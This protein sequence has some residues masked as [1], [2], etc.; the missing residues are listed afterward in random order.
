MYTKSRH[1][2][3]YKSKSLFK[4]EYKTIESS[5]TTLFFSILTL[6]KISVLFND[7]LSP[8]K[9]LRHQNFIPSMLQQFSI[10]NNRIQRKNKWLQAL[11]V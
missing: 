2:T 5:Q 9:P 6:F 11:V 8:L 7:L 10:L 1:K 4:Q 3:K